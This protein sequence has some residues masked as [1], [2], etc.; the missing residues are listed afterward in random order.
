MRICDLLL[1]SPFDQARLADCMYKATRQLGVDLAARWEAYA[2]L[3]ALRTS[4]M[5][6]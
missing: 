1:G 2:E 3:Q 6:V 4:A 5:W